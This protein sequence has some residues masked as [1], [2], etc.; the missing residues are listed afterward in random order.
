[1]E[2]TSSAAHSPREPDPQS[3][4]NETVPNHG[5]EHL[6]AD[7]GKKTVFERSD[8]VLDKVDR[9]FDVTTSIAIMIYGALAV[10]VAIVV[11]VL[12]PAGW[13]SSL[14]I[15]GYGVYLL[16]PGGEKLVVV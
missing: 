9:A 3:I 13:W 6:S 1:M 2:N 11:L 8:E 14:I 15:G 4:T 10:I 5:L 7:D 16:W 12:W